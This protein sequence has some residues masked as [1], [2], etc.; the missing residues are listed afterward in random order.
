MPDCRHACTHCSS[1]TFSQLRATVHICRSP[2]ARGDALLVAT[3]HAGRSCGWRA[4]RINKR[5]ETS[6]KWQAGSVAGGGG[7]INMAAGGRHQHGNNIWQHGIAFGAREPSYGCC[8]ARCSL[9]AGG[10]SVPGAYAMPALCINTVASTCRR[11]NARLRK[12]R[13]R[14]SRR[15]PLPYA[16]LSACIFVTSQRSAHCLAARSSF[17]LS[18]CLSTLRVRD[19]SANDIMARTGAAASS[20][21]ACVLCAST[22]SACRRNKRA[23]V[24]HRLARSAFSRASSLVSRRATRYGGE[25]AASFIAALFAHAATR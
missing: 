8:T 10:I 1:Y 23:S 15:R 3:S 19:S 14:A 21:V 4:A 17:A 13:S 11:G 25:R 2:F 5:G 6:S 16:H 20:P 18:R 7:D 12:A 22:T 24:A 9:M